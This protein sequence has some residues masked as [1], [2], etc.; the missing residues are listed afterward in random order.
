LRIWEITALFLALCG[1]A[2][3]QAPTDLAST[4]TALQIVVTALGGARINDIRTVKASGKI[5]MT[6]NGQDRSG[7]F[8]W[9]NSGAEF[10]YE[11]TGE[12]LDEVV[13]SGWGEPVSI[14]AGKTER[15]YGHVAISNLA[16]HL[17]AVVLFR[18]LSERKM[19]EQSQPTLE[20]MQEASFKD[21]S[22]VAFEMSDKADDTIGAYTRQ[23]WLIDPITSL[24]L[25]I[26]QWVPDR[27]DAAKLTQLRTEY[28]DF[29]SVDRVA[30]PFVIKTFLNDQVVASYTLNNVI[31]NAD[32]SDSD[33]DAPKE[34]Q[35]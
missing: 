22:V 20:V 10:R 15:L 23:R 2:A 16:P 19:L 28:G 4:K 11:T 17:P 24:P 32:V 26:T 18:W 13:I 1:I 35:Q 3:G 34:A 30:I 21:R 29:R 14:R 7:E 12:Q 27:S 6:I 9:K 25:A 33:F 5:V 8:V 31:F